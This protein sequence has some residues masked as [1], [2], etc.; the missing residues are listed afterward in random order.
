MDSD[1]S[2]DRSRRSDHDDSRR[3]L[4]A[5]AR[6]VLAERGPESLT[7]SEVAHRAGLNR[8]TAYQ[9]FRSREE[10][11]SAVAT[12]LGEELTRKLSESQPLWANLDD[13]LL[14]FVEQ[15]ELPRLVL[16]HL[17]S[18]NRIPDTSWSNLLG[19]IERYAPGQNSKAGADAEM[20][21]YVLSCVGILWPVIARAQ[22]EDAA[23]SREATS[24]MTRELKRLLLRGLLPPEA[25][26]DQPN[27]FNDKA[28]KS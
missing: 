18:E 26:P 5:A 12:E 25:W 9:H 27:L 6:L 3:R 14:Y 22:Y 13:L 10:L 28:S 17:L 7:V 15:P 21:G 20:L 4:L 19:V 24:R 11:S 1:A 8:S 23:A 2:I 16:Q